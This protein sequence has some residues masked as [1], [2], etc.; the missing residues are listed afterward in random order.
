[1]TSLMNREK[2]VKVERFSTQLG[3]GERI[4]EGEAMKFVNHTGLLWA[5]KGGGMCKNLIKT[6]E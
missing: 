2:V 6:I 5:E 4:K 3:L 1:V